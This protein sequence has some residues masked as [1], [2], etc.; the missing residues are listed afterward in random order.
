MF[1]DLI[2]CLD[3]FANYVW[4][5][6]WNLNTQEVGQ[7]SLNE[8][9]PLST[10]LFCHISHLMSQCHRKHVILS[11]LQEIYFIFTAQCRYLIR[12]YFSKWK[13]LDLKWK[14]PNACG[15]E[16][17]LYQYLTNRQSTNI[18]AGYCKHQHWIYSKIL[19][20]KYH[21]NCNSSPMSLFFD[22]FVVRIVFFFF[23]RHLL[24]GSSG[25]GSVFWMGM[26]VSSLSFAKSF[27][28]WG[29]VSSSLW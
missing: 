29:H 3:F 25:I 14:W 2:S 6:K 28:W 1:Q 7:S 26:S 17:S 20:T 12:T 24:M 23:K 15:W 4:S 13:N 18:G 11:K 5:F 21:K 8:K 27:G 10:F 16:V 19:S 9:N 22:R